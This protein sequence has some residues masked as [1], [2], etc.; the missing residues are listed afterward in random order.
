VDQSRVRVLL[1][2]LEASL[3]HTKCGCRSLRQE[4]V[5]PSADPLSNRVLEQPMGDGHGRAEQVT[6]GPD[7]LA[8][9]AAPMEDHLE[10]EVRDGGAGGTDMVA[11][12]D[13]LGATLD[14][15]LVRRPES[16]EDP[17]AL[18][19][20]ACRRCDGEDGIALELDEREVGLQPLDYG[21]QEAAEHRVAR[22]DPPA[23]V[24]RVRQLDAGHESRVAGDVREQQVP[25]AG[26]RICPWG[27]PGWLCLLHTLPCPSRLGCPAG[28][29]ECILALHIASERR[30]SVCSNC[31]TENDPGRK[32]CKECAARLALV[33]P[34]CG[35]ANG[36]DAKFC[37]E[38]AAPLGVET[39]SAAAT[40]SRPGMPVSDRSVVGP[41]AERRLVS[42]L[43][44]DLVGF[45]SLAEGR[46][47]EDTRELLTRYFDLARE[48]I[49]RYGG[50]V[51]K[52]IGDA[53]MA[54][55]GAP[56]AH[57]DDAERAVRSALELVDA[58]RSL[59][60]GISARAGVLTG[61][62]AVTVGATNQGM[63]AGDIVNTASRLQ[64]IAEPGTVVVGEATERAA[65]RAIA[66]EAI[67]EQTLKG[68]AL[69]VPAWRAVRVIAQ[70]GGR[71]RSETLEAPFVGRDDELRLIK[72]LFHA[73]TRERKARLVSVIGP[74]GI[75]KS[76]LAWEFRKYEDGLL[77]T[78]WFHDG[79]SPA[80]GDGISFWALGE[81]IRRRAGLLET[82]DEPTTRT[83]IAATVAEHVPDET[84]RRWIE[85]ALLALL[86]VDAGVMGSDE[87][88]AAWRAFF[89]RMAATA[90]VILVFE[91]F[92]Y[93]DSGLIDFVDHLLEWSRAFP[94]Y[95]LTLA[96]PELTERRPDWGAGKRSFTSIFLEPLSPEA[97]RELLAGL[98]PGLPE[99]AERAIIA[100]A[101]GIP[102]YAIET[103][104]ML[105]SEGRLTLEG[106]VYRPT[107]DLTNLAVPETLT[108]LIASRLDA[109]PPDERALAADA[110]VLGQSFTLPGL[111]SMS[112]LDPDTLATRLKALVR[113]ELLR[114]ETDPRS[115]ERGQYVF[116]QA[117]IREV[118][119]NALAKRDRKSRHLA[120]ARFFE[121]LETDE[122]A[123]GLAGHYLAAYRNSAE[124]AEA[125]AVA[126]QARIALMAAAQ[127]A[128]GLGSHDQALAFLDQALT[129]T[130]DPAESARL[131]ER[132]GDA[133]SAGGRYEAAEDRLRRAISAHRELGDRRAIASATAVLGRALISGRHGDVALPLLEA[134][135]A[136]FAD[137]DDAPALAALGGQLARA[138]FL[139]GNLLRAIEI[140]DPVL[141]TAQHLDMVPIVAD[142]LV[143]KGS[144]LVQDGRSIEGLALIRAGQELAE[145]HALADTLT[146]AIGNRIAMESALDPRAAL[147]IGRAGLAATRRLGYHD[148]LIIGNAAGAA[149]RVG[150]WAWG[151]DL[152]NGALDESF[153]GSERAELLGGTIGYHAFRGDPTTEQ[154]DEIE[155]LFGGSTDAIR[156]AYIEWARGN[157]AFAAGRLGEARTRIR[158]GIELTA[159]PD[160]LPFSARAALWDRDS[161][162]ARTDLAEL[163]AAGLHGGALEADRTTIRAGIAA[164]EGRTGDAI[165]LYR[166]ALREWRELGL[167]WDEA[168][169]G[170]DMASLLDP[171]DPEVRAAAETARETLVRLEAAPFIDRLDA[172]MTRSAEGTDHAAAPQGVLDVPIRIQ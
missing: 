9:G 7:R 19:V 160:G 83:K 98:I 64:S 52:F 114:L 17:A 96:R 150:E 87:L 86:G 115:P 8:H 12:R 37:G 135:S 68:K 132:A 39:G 106:S 85:P 143:T 21:V 157:V 97:M 95:V 66:F 151:L 168:L 146:R 148:A 88:F 131:L 100:R 140:A 112:G 76:R 55:W 1:A 163:D 169:C 30:L 31:G 60:P 3:G 45:T 91:D 128:I 108:A 166:A 79:R 156:V 105:V 10:I 164:L 43:F 32:F 153:E 102:L 117:L 134:A 127:R 46:D 4:Q 22:R 122:I 144:A 6:A 141:R 129:V 90:P 25:L 70:V 34:S 139:T 133:A 158:R 107:G 172:A 92:H 58:V 89:E 109:L 155:R 130:T 48:V 116:V 111:L 61:E 35:T 72:D 82:D 170:I 154:I 49:G 69:P 28:P 71:N 93:A 54:V 2:V 42:I 56:T 77:E 78:V 75:G 15:R 159:S 137:I 99:S 73:T 51:E 126:A 123:G 80:Y 41:L 33:C 74:A 104:R 84:E 125:D 147:E 167:A 53:V 50:T 113:R 23:E 81:M 26:R 47:A 110:A 124:G 16:L 138:H 20:E 24:D 14:E 29:A 18:A 62:A 171:A 63:V 57:E 121:S 27:R 103:I 44:A 142:T 94:I 65:S 40:A 13:G 162:A 59:G 152:L 119:Y 120:A 67:G 101:D 149:Q 5:W 38:C 161:D 136:E 118:A 11:R 36:A 165:A 145:K